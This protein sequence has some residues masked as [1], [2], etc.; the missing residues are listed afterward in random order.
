M[1]LTFLFKCRNGQVEGRGGGG[2]LEGAK[3][4]REVDLPIV[5]LEAT[6][7]QALSERCW[8]QFSG[9]R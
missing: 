1:F 5:G 6:L 9:R 7:Q 2:P 8:S 3:D 4:D